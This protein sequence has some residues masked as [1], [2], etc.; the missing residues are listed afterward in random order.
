VAIDTPGENLFKDKEQCPANNF[1]AKHNKNKT[2]I[3]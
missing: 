3:S 2:F 1:K